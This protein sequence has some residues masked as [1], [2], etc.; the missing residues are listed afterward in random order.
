[1]LFHIDDDGCCMVVCGVRRSVSSFC[2]VT[3]QLV[4]SGVDESGLHAVTHP[5]LIILLQERDVHRLSSSA[6]IRKQQVILLLLNRHCC[7][8]FPFVQEIPVGVLACLGT[9]QNSYF[10]QLSL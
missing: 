9:Q 7:C 1:M 5:S 2:F 8:I 6:K 10:N 3:Q 4:I